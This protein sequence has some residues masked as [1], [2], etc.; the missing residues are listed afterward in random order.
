MKARYLFLGTALLSGCSL[1]FEPTGGTDAASDSFGGDA[2]LP[3]DGGSI[4]IDAMAVAA[5]AALCD[6]FTDPDCYVDNYPLGGPYPRPGGAG[7]DGSD[8]TLS[9]ECAAS[10]FCTGVAG[11]E[12]YCLPLC[13]A[14]HQCGGD[15][16]CLSTDWQSYGFCEL[17]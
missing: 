9:S 13:D 12:G 8:C 1:L 10:M 5:D 11:T 2:S 4:D 17:L 14:E 6:P 7:V 16:A 15:R 3:A